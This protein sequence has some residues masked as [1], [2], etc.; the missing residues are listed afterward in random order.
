MR[1]PGVHT[2]TSLT[3]HLRQVGAIKDLEHEAKMLIE[4]GLP[5]LDDRGRSRD[6]NGICLLAEEQLAGNQASLNRLAEP[7]VV[8]D[9][10]VDAR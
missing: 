8:G 4:L 1:L 5:L 6:D 2:E 10:E 9:E 3:T 7:C